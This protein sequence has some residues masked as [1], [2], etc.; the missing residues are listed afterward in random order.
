[1]S[2]STEGKTEISRLRDE[3]Q[4]GT[5]IVSL[6]GLTSIASKAF[7]LS[8]LQA[9][10]EKNFAIITDSNKELE[11]WECDLN[12]WQNSVQSSKFKVQ[13]SANSQLSTL[14]S[15]TLVL[16]SFESDVYSGVSP[17]AETLE[18]R[19]LA[20]WNLTRNKPSFVLMSA[21]SL[22]T[23]TISP[24]EMK[25]LGAHLKRDD[26][27][28][29]DTLIETLSACG[30]VRE[31]PI[32]NIGEFSVRGGILDVW[33]PGEETPVRI[34]F[35]GDT[36]DSIRA[37]DPET[38]LSVRQL[39]EVALAPM[40]EFCASSQDFKEWAILARERFSD[41]RFTRTLKDR[42]E[43]ADEGESFSGWEFL[44]ALKNPRS[45]SIFDYL[46]D[47]VLV[48]DEPS[49]IEQNLSLFYESLERHYVE[50]DDAGEIG[51]KPNELFLSAEN[52]RE[53]LEENKRLELRALGKLAA[54]TDE[55]FK[56]NA[57]DFDV[58]GDFSDDTAA[59]NNHSPLAARHLFLFS[60]AEKAAEIEIGTRSTRKFHG[61][62][63][64]FANQ[65][66]VENSKP[67]VENQIARRSTA[68]HN[69]F[70]VLQSHGLAD[71][72]AEILRDYD[73]ILPKNALLIGDLSN[74][75]EIPSLGLTVHTETDLFGDVEVQASRFKIQNKS[76][77]DKRPTRK[78]K[79]SAF[80]SDFRDLK[81]GDYVVHV[82]HGI[83]RFEGLQT[84]ESGGV[85]RE[86]MLLI[87]AGSAKLFVPVERLDLV[88]RY[89]SGEAA[90]PALDRLGGLGWLKTKA[91]AKRAM[92]DM[93]DELLRL[94]AERKLV[95]GFA[96]SA[97]S[98]WQ[99]EF[100][101]AFPFELTPDQSVAVEDV[102]KDM[103]TLTPMDRLIVGDVGYGKTEVAMR[104]AFKA[105]MD[106]KQVA[107]LTPTTVLAYQHFE[108]FKKRFAAFPVNIE[109]LSRFRSP[110]E[111]KEVVAKAEKGEID[112]LI[113]THRILSNDVRLPKLGLVVVDEEQR[114]GV[115]HKEKLKQLK[116]KVDVVTLSATPI[117]RTLNM[118][119]LGMRDMSVIETPPRDRLA[120]NTQVVQF[121]EGVIK[122]AIE[123]EITRDGQVF[124]I[125]NRVET[126]TSIAALIQ[127]IVPNARIIVAHGQM[128]EKEMEQAMLD[129]VD[130]KY[131]V[132][133][134]TTII[135]NG[136]D[137]PRANT[138][139]INRADNYGLSQL[140]QLRGRVGRSSRRAYAYL[141]I[142][143]DFELT[144]IARRRLSAIREFS[145][146]G[147]GFRIAA[148]DLELR[149]AGNILGG[150][151]SGHLDALGFDLYVKMLERT[152]NELRGEAVEDEQSVSINLG[153][154]VSI[155]QDF[156]SETGQR[157]RTYKRISSSNTEEDLRRIYVEISD[158]YGRV[159]ESVENLF[160]YARLRRLAEEM[161]V[162]S[163]DKTPSGLAFKLGENA[164]VS[165]EKL[166]GFLERNPESSFTPSGV[167]KVVLSEETDNLLDAA[168]FALEEIRLED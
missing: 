141:L 147:A 79:T 58:K 161:R 41:Q 72:L 28:S 9:E 166:T 57:A 97:D 106:S 64:E 160:E 113:G 149:G 40:R 114:F 35:F 125:H 108:T 138:I 45:A 118:S 78:S 157:L 38:Q 112:V 115:A 2:F 63:K 29:L 132:L 143:S 31:E 148:L 73:I 27:F 101:G 74:G 25:N 53:N 90:Q 158:R 154:D 87:Y 152:I 144:P 135:E 95:Q 44:F 168:R 20:L 93:A 3:L 22:I 37:F 52:L 33:S 100:E 123:L 65:F 32:K 48:V 51:I 8:N 55:E 99:Q 122:S 12:F 116:K 34:E 131:D 111:Q 120:I 15:Q 82:D 10:T 19:A 107:V 43:F 62:L 75:F 109:L 80:I 167:L 70:I 83:G 17:H 85:A 126:I 146:L 164:K 153:I 98:P 155:P 24:N 89:S 88:S 137:I 16:P 159:P 119:L 14:N 26:D 81:P 39:K 150:Q 104:A 61:N 46:Q 156:I 130:Y 117:P 68:A 96:F 18:K 84:L 121:S 163:V 134:A 128:N 129:F 36:V 71:R 127:K 7:I 94:Y 76:V 42:T 133:V 102:K 30:Y 162:V 23:R 49:I 5:R 151:Q 1:M 92:R 11:T 77:N 86:F 145:E 110:R 91:K 13:S 47:C 124:F 60:T 59:L 140:Y 4:S 103:Q 54:Q 139:I 69:Q 105:A 21:K 67:K 6:G 142:P 56:Y 136:I 165:P 66:T 50:I